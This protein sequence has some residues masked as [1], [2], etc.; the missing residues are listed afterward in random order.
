MKAA[1]MLRA[2]CIAGTR[3]TLWTSLG[4]PLG[5]WRPC[6]ESCVL[7]SHVRV[8]SYFLSSLDSNTRAALEL[9]LQ[10]QCKW[11]NR[12]VCHGPKLTSRFSAAST[13]VGLCHAVH[14]TMRCGEDNIG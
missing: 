6:L 11:L 14:R 2:S 8:A 5:S 1:C 7:V 13:L 9:V 12:N 10:A 4:K 3:S